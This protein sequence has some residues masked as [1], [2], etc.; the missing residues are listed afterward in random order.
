MDD[1]SV[2]KSNKKNS[3]FRK[4]VILAVILFLGFDACFILYKYFAPTGGSIKGFSNYFIKNGG[5][6]SEE[7]D[8][9][10]TSNFPYKYDLRD[11]GLVTP[12]KSQNPWGS[13]WGF[14]AIAAA[15]TSILNDQGKT[16]YDTGLDLSEHQLV[17]FSK[18]HVEDPNST[19]NGEGVYINGDDSPLNYAGAVYTATS[20]F[21]SG[22]GVVSE[23]FI[24]YSGKN[25][26][27][28]GS[29]YNYSAD[30]DWSLDDEY[31]YVQDYELVESSILPSPC[32]RDADGNYLGYNKHGT[33]AIKKELLEGRAVSILYASDKYL[34]E[35]ETG[36][37]KYI[38][39]E[40]NYWTHYTYDDTP[41]N[42]AVTIVGYDDSISRE[43]F[44]DHTSELGEAYLPEGNG[45]W[46]CKNSWGAATE[47]FPN[48]GLW[49]IKDEYGQATGYF[50]LSY[51]DHSLAEPESFKFSMV[52]Y[53]NKEYVINQYDFL[54]SAAAECWYTTDEIK[55]A[56]VFKADSNQLLR[57]L[58]CETGTENTTV[59]VEV[60]LLEDTFTS[61]TNNSP[62]YSNTI[63]YSYAGYH[64]IELDEPIS[65]NAGQTYSVVLT[66]FIN[67]D[68]GRY[69]SVFVDSQLSQEGK[70]QAMIDSGEGVSE[71]YSYGVGIVNSSESY[72]YVENIGWHDWVEVVGDFANDKEY[73]FRTFDNFPIKAYCEYE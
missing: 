69:Y 13:C 29:I 16:Y 24:P 9:I 59:K 56:N 64:R 62:V 33:D 67:T 23:E 4:I 22:I 8:T 32:K 21:S 39:T 55:M 52:Q 27:D 2:K 63:E 68:V 11:Y 40:N 42:H 36:T 70:V 28:G 7:K 3:V 38:N 73:S 48:K 26:N 19:Q 50:Y 58:S 47:D 10:D 54:Q 49:G 1:I 34:P 51:Y 41:S 43:I 31:R 66:E 65:L 12:V 30:D 20:I 25:K 53:D 57:S 37:P 45:A 72:V 17:W 15:E 46:I 5:V 44:L 71:N 18:T 35:A 60:Y 6:A 14:A 61:L